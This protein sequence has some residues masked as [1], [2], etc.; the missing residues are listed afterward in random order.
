MKVDL[1]SSNICVLCLVRIGDSYSPTLEGD[2]QKAIDELP[3]VMNL[4]GFNSEL[5]TFYD[6]VLE[7]D[8]IRELPLVFMG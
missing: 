5:F 1:K 4:V 8:E 6:L 3:K 7:F 2:S